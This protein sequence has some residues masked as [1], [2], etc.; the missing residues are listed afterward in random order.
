[1]FLNLLSNSFSSM[2][3][4]NS[5]V[6][7]SAFRKSFGSPI[8]FLKLVAVK[9]DKNENNHDVFLPSILCTTDQNIKHKTCRIRKSISLV[10]I[11]LKY[12]PWCLMSSISKRKAQ[13]MA[14]TTKIHSILELTWCIFLVTLKLCS[15]KLETK[16]SPNCLRSSQ[17]RRNSI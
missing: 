10:N 16:R 9:I 12:T 6:H 1:M 8:S 3:G 2:D 15:G 11:R 13:K 7:V 14:N 17:N 5:N 4:L